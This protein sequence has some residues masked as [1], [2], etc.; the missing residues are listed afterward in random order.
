MSALKCEIEELQARIPRSNLSGQDKQGSNKRKGVS[1]GKTRRRANN[2]GSEV[3]F[4]TWGMACG[5]KAG[6]IG[7]LRQQPVAGDSK[8]PTITFTSVDALRDDAGASHWPRCGKLHHQ[9]DIGRTM[10]AS[11]D[12]FSS[13]LKKMG[14]NPDP[15]HTASTIGMRWERN[16]RRRMHSQPRT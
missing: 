9:A 15:I 5:G 8:K 10:V 13:T 6:K 11:V 2:G 3:P 16:L 7:G 14:I 1:R 4:D 12:M